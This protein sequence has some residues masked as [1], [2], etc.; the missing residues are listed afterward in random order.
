MS[1]R[2]TAPTRSTPAPAPWRR[3]RGGEPQRGHGFTASGLHPSRRW[4]AHFFAVA[5]VLAL[6]SG[7]LLPAGSTTPAKI[8]TD[9]I[10]FFAG[11]TPAKRKIALLQNGEKFAAIIDGQAS[12]PLSKSVT[13]TV[14]AVTVLSGTKAKVRYSLDLGG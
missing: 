6:A 14:A 2:L 10:A 1:P 8:K 7:S 11:S 3:G 4:P 12:S 13:A 5:L 9:W